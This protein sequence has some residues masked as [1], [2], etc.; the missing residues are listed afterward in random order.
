MDGLILDLPAPEH[1][2]P[3]ESPVCLSPLTAQVLV[4]ALVILLCV[5]LYPTKG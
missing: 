5:A 2:A 4:L 1:V 3:F